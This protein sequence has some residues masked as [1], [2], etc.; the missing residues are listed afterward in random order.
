MN[1][2]TVIL[3]SLVNLHESLLDIGKRKQEILVK[4]EIDPLLSILAE[5]SKVMKKIKEADQRRLAILGEEAYQSSL[6][7]VMERFGTE[8]EKKEWQSIYEQLQ[9][10]F[11][12]LKLV[13]ES[14]QKLLQHS[15]SLTQY[16]IEQMLPKTESPNFYHPA[17]AA[18]ENR[19]SIRFFDA[20][21]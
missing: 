18:K 7:E 1:E 14:N 9:Q 21:A 11:R 16:M 15:L 3:Q 13:N 6:T 10:L 20:K 17:S 8:D 5:E 4:G 2:F 19:D 12:E